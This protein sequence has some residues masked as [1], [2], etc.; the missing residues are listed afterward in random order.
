MVAGVYVRVST[1]EQRER[2][3]IETQR[4]FA[5][6]Y[7]ELHKIHVVE[8]YSD[9]GVT[10]TLPL[11]QRPAGRRLLQDARA[12]KFDTLFF[13]KLDRL[14]RDPRMTLNAV[15]ELES[16]GIKVKSMTEPFDTSDATGRF[17]LTILS[18][19]AGL[20]RETFL[21]RSRAGTERLARDGAWL[22][23]IV[24]FGYRVEGKKRE[25]RLIISQEPLPGVPMSEADVIRMI[26]HL[27]ANEGWSCLTIAKRLGVLGVPPSYARDGRKVLRAKR[28]QATA[29]VWWPGR[30]RNIISSTTYR[31]LHCYGRRS[32]KHRDLI[33]RQ[34]PAIV[35]EKTWGRAQKTLLRNRIQAVRNTR[36]QYL[37][38]GLVECGQC[39][40]NYIGSSDH[41]QRVFYKCN[42]KHQPRGIYGKRGQLCPSKGISGEIEDVVWADIEEFLR[43]PGQVLETLSQN[44]D[45][46]EG[47]EKALRREVGLVERQLAEK[48][49]E[50]DRILTLYR[51]GTIGDELLDRQMAEIERER[52]ELKEALD[53]AR[54]RLTGVQDATSHLDSADTLL[55]ELN[56]RLDDPLTWELKREIVETLVEGIRVDTTEEGGRREAIVHVTYRFDPPNA[57]VVTRTDTRAVHNQGSRIGRSYRYLSRRQRASGRTGPADEP[58]SLFRH[59]E[60]AR[61]R[62]PRDRASVVIRP[63]ALHEPA[64]EVSRSR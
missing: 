34:V 18:G 64:L 14:G 44:A 20:E 41:G 11:S 50:R 61:S 51:R 7:C 21:E 26:Y 48:S 36:R 45:G 33:E 15:N 32:T 63:T 47:S 9:D 54:Q 39:G 6:Q 43:D 29:G 42:G 10:G 12:G 31:G 58:R 2:Q 37:L 35:D 23:G 8:V 3:T 16:F 46:L 56:R 60:L 1:E 19:V 4:Q 30:I 57:R 17:L 27:S 38:R 49:A 13:Y 62:M 22:G 24:P 59:Y 40:L 53:E 5:Q 25:A 55:R 52:R 28:K